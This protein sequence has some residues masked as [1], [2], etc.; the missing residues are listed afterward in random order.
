MLFLEGKGNELVG[1]LKDK[2]MA[3]ALN[4]H[5]ELAGHYRDQLRDIERSVERQRVVLGTEIDC[6]VIGLYREGILLELHLLSFRG[7]RLL[8]SKAFPQEDKDT[9]TPEVLSSFLS[10]YYA[11]AS[12]FPELVLLSEALPEEGDEAF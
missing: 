2:M 3:A 4:Q 12:S 9:P 1:L 7:G 5:Y 8:E 6:D 11:N 10:Q